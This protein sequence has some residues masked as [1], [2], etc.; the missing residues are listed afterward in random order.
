MSLYGFKARIKGRPYA[1]ILSVFCHRGN[2]V[3]RALGTALLACIVE[4]KY[5][6]GFHFGGCG[7]DP[8]DLQSAGHR[9]H[10]PPTHPPC[11][12]GCR[13][14]VGVLSTF[15]Y[16]KMRRAVAGVC[17]RSGDRQARSECTWTVSRGNYASFP[18]CKPIRSQFPRQ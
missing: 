5:R 12:L 7:V 17:I 16:S 14:C 6:Y 18:A 9:T 3:S 15:I 2:R 4:E 10:V 11:E 13:R 8:C 1:L